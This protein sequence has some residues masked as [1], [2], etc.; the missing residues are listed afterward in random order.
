MLL[1]FLLSFSFRFFLMVSLLPK[2]GPAP[3]LLMPEASLGG[4]HGFLFFAAAAASHSA[5][6]ALSPATRSACA[7]A[8]S[9]SAAFFSLAVQ[10]SGLKKSATPSCLSSLGALRAGLGGF[11]GHSC[12][13]L[14]NQF[15]CKLRVSLVTYFFKLLPTLCEGVRN[16]RGTW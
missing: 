14:I 10:I 16:V 15:Q 13:T 5:Y 8:A 2:R 6:A 7:F 11:L 12:I 9:P 4:L 1:G 3:L